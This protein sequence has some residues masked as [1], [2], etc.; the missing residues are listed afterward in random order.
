MSKYLTAARE[1]LGTVARSYVTIVVIALLVGAA[2]APIAWGATSE[3]DGTVAVIEMDS[4][5]SEP[6]A[7]PVIDDLREARQN[8][9]IDA[10]VLSVDSPGGGVTASESLYLAV[11]RTAQEMPVVTSVRSV[12]AS[13]GYYMSAPSDKI[14][15]TPSST[16]GSIGVRA[17]HMDAPAPEQEITTGPDKSGMTEEQVKQQAEQMKQTFLGSVIEQ[18]GDE[19]ELSEHELAYANVYVGVEAVENGL[20]DEI[21]DTEAAIGTAADEAGLGDYEV[22][23]LSDG[24]PLGMPLLFEGDGQAEAKQHVHPQTFGEYNGVETP[25]FLAVW[26]SIEG[27]TVADTTPPET[28]NATAV[29]AGGDQP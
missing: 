26:G 24:Q 22:V 4:S 8:E 15:A 12:G 10:V 3:A 9:S 23:E 28:Q 18:R 14:Y 11:E 20:V 16:V 2:I 19:L 1:L 25:A 27:Q 7:D 29:T 6:T 21:G 17:T 5:I 13:G